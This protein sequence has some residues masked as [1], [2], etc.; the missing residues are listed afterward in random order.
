MNSKSTAKTWT[1]LLAFVA[2]LFVNQTVIGDEAADATDTLTDT[3]HEGLPETSSRATESLNSDEKSEGSTLDLSLID[4]ALEASDNSPIG[5]E[6]TRQYLTDLEQAIYRVESEFNAYDPAIAELSEDLASRLIQIG[7]YDDALVAYRR[8]LHVLRINE[9]LDSER[10]IPILEQIVETHYRSGDQ[11]SAGKALDRLSFVYDQNFG[12]SDPQL[13]PNLVARGNWHLN[14]SSYSSANTTLK[15]L[16]EAY[17][18]YSRVAFITSAHGLP[19]DSEVYNVLSTTVYRIALHGQVFRPDQTSRF[20]VRSRTSLRE[21]LAREQQ[22]TG[23][24]AYRRGKI[25]LKNALAHANASGNP[26]HKIKAL[27][28]IGDWEQLFRKRFSAK[29]YYLEAYSYLAQLTDDSELHAFFD[30]PQ[31]LPDYDS[32]DRL[33]EPASAKTASIQVSLGV[34]PWGVPKNVK[35]ITDPDQAE[36]ALPR[37][38]VAE[39]VAVRRTSSAVYRP[40][41][42]DGETVEATDVIQTINVPN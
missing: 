17:N 26:E 10:Q 40:R 19:Y 21:S 36:Q 22:N 6:E 25:Q 12:V 18:A 9:G 33:V 37:N 32:V 7:Q 28:Q 8:A 13:V 31:I 38:L 16:Q 23:N 3:A 39:R 24:T 29:Q 15:H 11:E 5:S 4:P 41:I 2:L 42:V 35:L 34:S 27:V 30:Q 14:A 20:D 1:A